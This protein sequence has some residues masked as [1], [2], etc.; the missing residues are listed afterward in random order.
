M[1]MLIILLEII[2]SI[3]VLLS[4]LW[5]VVIFQDLLALNMLLRRCF[6][7]FGSSAHLIL[8]CAVARVFRVNLVSHA[9]L[10]SCLGSYFERA[11]FF[12][13]SLLF[14]C[15]RVFCYSVLLLPRTK[16]RLS[17]V[18][19]VSY[20]LVYFSTCAWSEPTLRR[21]YWFCSVLLASSNIRTSKGWELINVNSLLFECC[22]RVLG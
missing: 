1:S 9:F 12:I 21:R 6:E 13:E 22:R 15:F 3:Q 7:V 8:R 10:G 2:E 14:H 16:P 18:F 11:K 19:S 20:R 17:H 4:Q 5:P